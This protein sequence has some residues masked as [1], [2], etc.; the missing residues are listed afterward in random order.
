MLLLLSLAAC[1]CLFWFLF[2]FVFCLGFFLGLFWFWVSV[3]YGGGLLV[4]ELADE[5]GLITDRA[6]SGAGKRGEDRRGG[7]SLF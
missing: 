6:S 5:E 2:G 4:V 7:G 3:W 1:V